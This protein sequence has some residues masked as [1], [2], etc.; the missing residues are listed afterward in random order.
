MWDYFWE[1]RD[2]SIVNVTPLRGF[3]IDFMP[4]EMKVFHSIKSVFKKRLETIY[5]I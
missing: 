2:M 4:S 3:C 5:N 1:V